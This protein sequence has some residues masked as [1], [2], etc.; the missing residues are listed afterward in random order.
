MRSFT[1]LLALVLLGLSAC[2][3]AADAQSGRVRPVDEADR[4]PS[5]FLFRGRLIQAVAEHDTSFVM[6][7]VAPDIRTG[8][9]AEG[10]IG[11][12]REM[13]RP[14]DVDSRLW[15]T[16]GRIL[17]LGGTFDV[18]PTP[19]DSLYRFVAPYTFSAFPEEVDA[20]TYQVVTGQSVRVRQAPNLDAA[21][22]DTLSYDVVEIRGPE[23][24]ADPVPEGW[25]RVVLDDGRE[26]YVSSDFLVSSLD[27]RAGFE[28]RDGRWMLVYLVAGD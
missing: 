22:I 25:A 10:G 20:F 1:Q 12:F 18:G 7:H 4:D 8:F 23:T 13:W 26:G 6:A 11:H 27:Y 21:V 16:L 19:G 2:T 28:R 5:F 14:G 24:G 9:G 17:G 15:S 3:P